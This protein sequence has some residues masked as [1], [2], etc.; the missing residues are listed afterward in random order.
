MTETKQRSR[1]SYVADVIR[2][3]DLVVRLLQH[4]EIF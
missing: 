3:V 1:W 2:V 4:F